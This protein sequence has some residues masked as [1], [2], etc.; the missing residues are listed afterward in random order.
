MTLLIRLRQRSAP[1]PSNASFVIRI[2]KSRSGIQE[3]M[4]ALLIL[5]THSSTRYDKP[6]SNPNESRNVKCAHEVTYKCESKFWYPTQHT[7][8]GRRFATQTASSRNGNRYRTRDRW[9]G[10]F[11]LTVSVRYPHNHGRFRLACSFARSCHRVK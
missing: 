1:R 11:A 10:R 6:G 8:S 2:L 4:S 3:N 7:H 5:R 9:S